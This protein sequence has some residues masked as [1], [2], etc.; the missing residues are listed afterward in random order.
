MN[1]INLRIL[2]PLSFFLFIGFI[3]YL[4]DTADHNFAFRVIGQIPYGDKLMHGLL[5]GVMALLLNYGLN[6][7]SQKILGFNMQVGALLV[8]AFAGLEEISQYWLPSRTCD[9]FDFVADTVGVILFSFIKW[10]EEQK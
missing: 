10:K 2:L 1:H 8:L 4:A 5:Y 6:F 3:I 9:M 7:K